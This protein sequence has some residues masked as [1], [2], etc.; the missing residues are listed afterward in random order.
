MA[1]VRLT[2]DADLKTQVRSMTDYSTAVLSATKLDEVVA[3]AKAELMAEVGD[4]T[5]TFYGDINAERA[6]FWTTCLFT[7]IKAGELDGVPMSLGDIEFDALRMQGE[8]GSGAVV[9]LQNAQQYTNRLATSNDAA[10]YGVRSID[11]GES[12]SYGGDDSGTLGGS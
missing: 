9:W 5:L 7:K 6:L 8:Y 1:P 2:S 11:R 12:R 10:R 4:T 3:T